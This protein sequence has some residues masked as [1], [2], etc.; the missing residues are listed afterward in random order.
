MIRAYG[1]LALYLIA[2]SE[3]GRRG[4]VGLPCRHVVSLEDQGNQIRD[5]IPRQALRIVLRHRDANA[6]GQVA[7]R[8]I[9]PVA[10]E[11]APT[12]LGASPPERSAP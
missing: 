4:Q 1:L 2:F 8:E 10:A 3:F 11:L 5:L 12:R 7:E 9:V 6:L